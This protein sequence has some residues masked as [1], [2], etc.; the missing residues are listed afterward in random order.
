MVLKVCPARDSE[1]CGFVSVACIPV[2]LCLLP[3]LGPV[4]LT[5]FAGGGGG[6]E[7]S[8]RNLGIWVGGHLKGHFEAEIENVGEL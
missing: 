4:I 5:D 7:A 3:P 1:F 8:R 2:A 6:S